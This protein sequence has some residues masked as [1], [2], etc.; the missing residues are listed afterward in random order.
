MTNLRNCWCS[1]IFHRLQWSTHCPRN[2][3]NFSIC[4]T[5]LYVQNTEYSTEA[6]CHWF[7]S[8]EFHH[9]EPWM[10]G[11][12]SWKK[13]F[14]IDLRITNIWHEYKYYL[15]KHDRNIHRII[16]Y[17]DLKA[18]RLTNINC[19]RDSDNAHY[20]S[21]SSYVGACLLLISTWAKHGLSSMDGP[22]NNNRLS[23]SHSLDNSWKIL[24]CWPTQ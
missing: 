2:T 18:L 16:L 21:N 10:Q 22:D 14:L 11:S 15:E 13:L 6:H 1:M 4:K 5:C 8:K 19:R 24:R 9:Y 12:E 7:S 20:K 17:L 3:C 23:K